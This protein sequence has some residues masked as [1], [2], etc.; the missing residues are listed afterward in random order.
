MNLLVVAPVMSAFRLAVG[1][2]KVSPGARIMLA[3]PHRLPSCAYQ[4]SFS[5]GLRPACPT[6]APYQDGICVL[7]GPYG[8]WIFDRFTEDGWE[9]CTEGSGSEPEPGSSLPRCHDERSTGRA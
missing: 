1:L 7:L 8:L 9:F 3:I 2:G 6:C 4:F 5:A